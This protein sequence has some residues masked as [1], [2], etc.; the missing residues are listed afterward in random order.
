MNLIELSNEICHRNKF[1]KED[2]RGILYAENI[3]NLLHLEEL[4]YKSIEMGKPF[5]IKNQEFYRGIG[6][7]SLIED[8]NNSLGS[9]LIIKIN[10]LKNHRFVH[11]NYLFSR[12]INTNQ[13]YITD[14]S[15]NIREYE[16]VL[17]HNPRIKLAGLLFN[18]KEKRQM[19]DFAK[20]CQTTW[21]WSYRLT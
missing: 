12:G 15:L 4:I 16:E 21:E 20:E 3:K 13:Y 7:S 2:E 9:K 5:Y 10:L 11:K 6:K 1:F 17:K 19:N 14:E 18:E 8:I